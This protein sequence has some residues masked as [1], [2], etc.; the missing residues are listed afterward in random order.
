VPQ[1]YYPPVALGE[2]LYG[3]PGSISRAIVNQNQLERDACR[4]EHISDC[5]VQGQDI[6]CFIHRGNDDAQPRPFAAFV[7]DAQIRRVN[8]PVDRRY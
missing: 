7:A 8:D 2:G 5:P 1:P 6:A 4:I 3:L